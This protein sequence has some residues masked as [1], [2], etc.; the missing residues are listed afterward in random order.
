M[1]KQGTE[2]HEIYDRVE[3][4]AA[5][6]T[7]DS[8]Q[9]DRRHSNRNAAGIANHVVHEPGPI[10]MK[11]GIGLRYSA[12]KAEHKCYEQ[13]RHEVQQLRILGEDNNDKQVYD[14][15]RRQDDNDAPNNNAQGHQRPGAQDIRRLWFG[16]APKN[17]LD[18]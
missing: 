9:Q 3:E 7:P 14:P 17:E 2:E 18:C 11:L 5:Y 10:K 15:P 4:S 1:T 6:G 12:A 16:H 8:Q 13:Y